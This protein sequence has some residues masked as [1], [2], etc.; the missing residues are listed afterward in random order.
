MIVYRNILLKIIHW[1][2]K[3]VYQFLYIL[4]IFKVRV[5]GKNE[6]SLHVV[7]VLLFH[8]QTLMDYTIYGVHWVP[9]YPHALSHITICSLPNHTR[10]PP[11]NFKGVCHE[12]FD[13]FI[14]PISAYCNPRA[15]KYGKT[16]CLKI[17]LIYRRGCWYRWLTFPFEYIHEFS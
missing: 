4:G 14:P 1:E 2:K 7:L 5:N 10:L 9:S 6:S 16:S 11:F 17:F 13:K 15:T 12:I 3:R 8:V